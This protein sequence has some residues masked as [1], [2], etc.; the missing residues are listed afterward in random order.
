MKYLLGRATGGDGELGVQTN[1]GIITGICHRHLLVR[2]VA[3]KDGDVVFRILCILDFLVYACV[4][5]VVL[6]GFM[7][8]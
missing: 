3:V 8:V 6:D 5:S 7:S 1:A 4:L 2:T